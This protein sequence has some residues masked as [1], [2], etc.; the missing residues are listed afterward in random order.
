MISSKHLSKFHIGKKSVVL[1]DMFPPLLVNSEILFA[2][3]YTRNEPIYLTH[4]IEI[5]KFFNRKKYNRK[6]NISVLI[7]LESLQANLECDRPEAGSELWSAQTE[8]GYTRP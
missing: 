5:N 8:L 3:P 1:A 6:F 4:N 2:L 7:Y